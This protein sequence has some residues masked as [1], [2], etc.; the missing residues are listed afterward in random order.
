[1]SDTTKAMIWSWVKV[2]AAAVLSA[3]VAIVSA[4]KEL[5]TSSEAWLSVLVAGILAVGP[6]II[7]YFNPHDPRY[8]KGSE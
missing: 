5:P 3:F 2:F 8:G 1:M 4:T 6:V 7:N